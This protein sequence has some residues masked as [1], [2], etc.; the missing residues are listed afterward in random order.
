MRI[1]DYGGLLNNGITPPGVK[2][3][4]GE[5]LVIPVLVSPNP[6]NR[7]LLDVRLEVD[8]MPDPA[9]TTVIELHTEE[10]SGKWSTDGFL[11]P[12]FSPWAQGVYLLL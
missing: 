5:P 7:S 10:Q 1:Q 4:D 3:E 2:V 9:E 11:Q 8:W 12:F 6:I